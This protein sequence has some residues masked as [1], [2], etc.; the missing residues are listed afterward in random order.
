MKCGNVEVSIEEGLRK[1]MDRPVGNH[2]IDG[3]GRSVDMAQ[4][5]KR[6]SKCTRPSTSN[7]CL[8]VGGTTATANGLQGVTHRRS[9]VF[10]G[11]LPTMVG[12]KND[13]KYPSRQTHTIHVHGNTDRE[14]MR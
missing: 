12:G 7:V 9:I 2:Q 4:V 14:L 10:G 13:D 8:L 3:G 11:D 5:G 6:G 1:D